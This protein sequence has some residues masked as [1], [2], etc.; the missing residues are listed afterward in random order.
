[1]QNL[2][3]K[4]QR[5]IRLPSP[6]FKMAN[7]SKARF[8]CPIC[9]YQGPFRDADSYAGPRLHAE[10]PKCGALERH[11]LQYLVVVEIL[12]GRDLSKWRMLHCAPEQFFS[13]I[14]SSRIGQYETADLCRRGV[15][16]QVDLQNLPFKDA[17]YDFIFASHVLQHIPD[18]EKAI[19]EIRRV[20]KAGGIAVLPVPVVCEKTI[21]YKEPNPG[22]SYYW[23][24]PG[25]DY[26]DRYR[27]HFATVESRNSADLPEKY[28]TYS[29][30][31][32]SVWPT[33]ACPLRPPMAGRR[34]VDFVPVCYA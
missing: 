27:A 25:L 2:V 31:D 9:R 22:E 29:Y 32:R 13:R 1:M 23:R 28:Q 15:Q 6:L 17:T 24:L 30:E 19:A 5:R 12:N 33:P 16:H 26:F 14:F 8:E 20:L 7:R 4:I 3:P 34:H 11:R 18:D 21:E 10:C